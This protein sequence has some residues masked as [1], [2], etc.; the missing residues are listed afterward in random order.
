VR[1]AIAEIDKR[2]TALVREHLRPR[3]VEYIRRSPHRRGPAGRKT[4]ATEI[5][6]GESAHSQF[7]EYL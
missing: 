5:R 4:A 7:R 3:A 2:L 1:D 6:Q